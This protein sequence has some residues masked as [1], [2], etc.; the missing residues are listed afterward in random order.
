MLGILNYPPGENDQKKWVEHKEYLKNS[1]LSQQEKKTFTEVKN[2]VKV[3]TCGR[4]N[5]KADFI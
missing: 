2:C 5:V 1:S 3:G 4:V